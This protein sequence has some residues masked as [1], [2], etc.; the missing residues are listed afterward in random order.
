MLRPALLLASSV[1]IACASPA[2]NEL[3]AAEAPAIR[4]LAPVTTA[5]VL[6]SAATPAA[7][8]EPSSVGS[9]EALSM[10]PPLTPGAPLAD[11]GLRHSRFTLK[12]GIYTADADEISDDGWIFNASWM[13]FFT[14]LLALEFEAGYLDASGEDGGVDADLWGIPLMVN[15]RA[16]L[17]VWI[18]D[19]YGG[20]GVGTIY[21]DAEAEAGG[22]SVEDDGFLLAGNAF[23]GATI[24]VADAIAVG[25]EAKYYVTDESDELD[26]ALDAYAIM[27]TVGFSR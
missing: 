19:V 5:T 23:L 11:E 13:R 8:A 27:L 2:S 21:Y 24:N 1:F 26:E 9:P 14:S 4:P 18:L 16:N 10:D 7:A 20:L 12:G 17:P 25:L 6:D 15:G 22:A 3:I